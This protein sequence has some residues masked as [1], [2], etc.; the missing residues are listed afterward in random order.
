LDDIT[1]VVLTTQYQLP[2]E[3]ISL[4]PANTRKKLV[5]FFLDLQQH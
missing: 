4:L 5:N 2:A 1:N 3:F